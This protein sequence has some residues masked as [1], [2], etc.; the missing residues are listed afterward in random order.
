MR[1]DYID[2]KFEKIG[3]GELKHK[4]TLLLESINDWP[5][6]VITTDDFCLSLESFVGQNITRNN[7]T[8]ALK[9]INY[10]ENAWEAESISQLVALFNLYNDEIDLN[11]IVSDLTN[12]L[13][14]L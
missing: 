11:T 2:D 14:S 4:L 3:S 6:D 9:K 10:S 8:T 13:A 1:I 7:L 12:E 5:V